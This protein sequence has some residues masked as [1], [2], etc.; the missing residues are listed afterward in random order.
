MSFNPAAVRF[1][2]LWS[3]FLVGA[4][5]IS[6]LVSK[7]AGKNFTPRLW[8]WLAIVV[9]LSVSINFGGWYFFALTACVFAVSYWELSR[10]DGP[11]GF[12]RNILALSLALPWLALAQ[13]RPSP[14][15]ISSALILFFVAVLYLAFFLKKGNPWNLFLF[16]LI[17]GMGFSFWILL[18][19]QGGARLVVFVFSITAIHDILAFF[20]GK[21]MGRLHIFPRLSPEKTLVGYLGGVFFAVLAAHVFRFAVPELN[22]FQVT[23]AGLLIALFGSAG[24][25]LASKV[26]RIYG[27]KDFSSILGLMGGM[28]DRCDSLLSAGWIFS[29]IFIDIF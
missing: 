24:D 15:W 25:L 3:I 12:W 27:V 21:L 8:V 23:A 26:K 6:I 7:Y 13:L 19:R 29:I 4:L 5:L 28:L 1:L 18:G 2:L 20:F 11:I 9:L 17:L 16:A 10:L 14:Q 22:T